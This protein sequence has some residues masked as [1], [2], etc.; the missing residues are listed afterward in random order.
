MKLKFFKLCILLITLPALNCL[1][2]NFQT[3]SKSLLVMHGKNEEY[4][5]AAVVRFENGSLYA[6][7]TQSVF[8]SGMPSFKLR[9][10]AGNSIKPLKVDIA[11]DRDLIRIQIN[12]N[13]FIK[14]F[15]IG[16]APK[17]IYQI[18]NTVGVISIKSFN[19]KA[20]AVPGSVILSPDGLAGFASVIK[21]FENQPQTTASIV[22]IDNKVKWQPTNF[23]KFIAQCRLLIEL[24]NKTLSLE[25]I[26]NS[27][28]NTL[29]EFQ[30]DFSPSH[31]QWIN[32][33]NEQYEKYLLSK[34]KNGKTMQAAKIQHEA[35]CSFYSDMRGIS[36]FAS[37]AAQT[38]KITRWFSI[39]LKKTAEILY[40]RNKTI[41]E[42][43]KTRMKQLLKAHPATKAKF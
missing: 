12:K 16:G 31:I 32:H 20:L 11:T 5:L 3:N 9:D 26:M 28:S 33:H 13:D 17:S 6:V 25:Q 18:S 30:P 37:N 35:R 34:G 42:R 38:A 7:T 10:F 41:N 29:I 40:E 23:I 24:R 36:I 4:A 39:F 8:L 14:P 21:G 2:S 1:G 19:Q 22:K 27:G 43:M 15:K